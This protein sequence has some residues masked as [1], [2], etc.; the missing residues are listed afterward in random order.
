[1]RGLRR[2]HGRALGPRPKDP[3]RISFDPRCFVRDGV[4]VEWVVG[5][6]IAPNYPKNFGAN[7]AAAREYARKTGREWALRREERPRERR[8]AWECPS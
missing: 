8:V 6:N 5:G 3:S 1:M 2:R 7:E 4:I